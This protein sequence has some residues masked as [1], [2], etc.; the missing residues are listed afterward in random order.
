MFWQQ[1]ECARGSELMQYQSNQSHLVFKREVTFTFSCQGTTKNPFEA[2]I[3]WI[4]M[5][6]MW[7]LNVT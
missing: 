2:V 1:R 5:L 7:R 4:F 3:L 6:H